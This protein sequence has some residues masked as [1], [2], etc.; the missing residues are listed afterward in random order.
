VG[1]AIQQEVPGASPRPLAFFSAKLSPAQ[2]KYS[3]F[4][5]EFLACYLAIRHFRWLLEGRQFYLVTGHKPL[6]YALACVSDAW[7]ARQQQQLSYVAE[8]T[9]DIRHMPGKQNMVVDALSRHSRA[10]FAARGSFSV[11]Q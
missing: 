8:Y 1:A 10:S 6:T 7:S 11:V 9:A 4:D 2:A 3:A 5:R